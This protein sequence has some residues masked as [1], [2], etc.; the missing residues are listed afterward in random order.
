MK[1]NDHGDRCRC[2]FSLQKHTAL[3]YQKRQVYNNALQE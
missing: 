2:T 3:E 1:K